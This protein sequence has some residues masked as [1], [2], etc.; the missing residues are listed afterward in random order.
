MM[1]AHEMKKVI[2][3]LFFKEFHAN[4]VMDETL[5]SV[6]RKSSNHSSGT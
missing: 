5:L 2:S 3:R 6:I 4:L 1:P